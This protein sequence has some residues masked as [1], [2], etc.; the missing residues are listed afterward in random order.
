ME[1]VI[2]DTQ[3]WSMESKLSTASSQPQSA[4]LPHNNDICKKQSSI[5]CVADL[6]MHWWAKAVD[7]DSGDRIRYRCEP[8]W[9]FRGTIGKMQKMVQKN[10]CF[11]DLTRH[12]KDDRLVMWGL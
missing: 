9:T 2:R 7:S 4:Y 10:P 12:T 5:S 6:R 8:C 3:A 1:Q 11:G